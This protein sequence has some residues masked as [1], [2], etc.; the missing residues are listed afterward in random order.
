MFALPG[1]NNSL[2]QSVARGFPGSYR[3]VVRRAFVSSLLGSIVL[4]GFGAYYAIQHAPALSSG[5]LL[6]ALFFPFASGL[7]QWRSLK[8][9]SEDFA[10]MFK[11]DGIAVVVMT[12]LMIGAVTAYPGTLLAPLAVVFGVQAGLNLLLTRSA[13]RNVPSNAP[14]EAGTVS[15]GTKTTFFSAFSI[16]AKQLDKVLIFLLL[17][18][19]SLGLFVA[20]ERIPELLKGQ[21]Q[22]LAAVLAPR[23]AK[24]ARYTNSLDRL[25][26]TAG[27][28][29][30]GVTVLTAFT[31]LPYAIRFVF[32]E[33]YVA[34]IP[35]SQALMCSTAIGNASILRLRYVTSKFDVE[36]PR[37]V[38]ILTSATR[39][40][41][42]LVLV[43][44]LGL[45][46]A[47]ISAFAYRVA[48]TVVVHIVIKKN[49]LAG[50][51]AAR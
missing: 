32:G 19:A 22:D 27:L 48:M 6:V 9:G 46:G 35:Y 7:E 2:M 37:V 17:S 39:I 36:S 15:H 11:M 34:A 23:F 4:I 42:S 8:S 45:L 41:A 47:V 16:L 40:I 49:Y 10:G 29:T 50:E 31:V 12:V 20:A 24:R 3:A 21:F 13:L 14:A 44:L 30:S 5:F 38:E 1:L 51:A 26:R 18:P 43:P 33:A 25:L 28:I